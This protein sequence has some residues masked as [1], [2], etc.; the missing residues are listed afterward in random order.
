MGVRYS[1]VS[2][3]DLE[4]KVIQGRRTSMVRVIMDRCR[5][6]EHTVATES[7]ALL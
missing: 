7:E 5:S 6:L 1:E 3:G 4:R 2:S